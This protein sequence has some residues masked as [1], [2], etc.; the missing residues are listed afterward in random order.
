M[1]RE[2]TLDVAIVG[3]GFAGLYMLYKAREQGMNAKVFER[4]DGVGG[5]WYWNRYPGARC[6]VESF[7]YSYSF[8]PELD[9]EWNW[10]ERYPTQPE[11]LAYLNHVADRFDLRD[12]I[13]LETE[14]VSAHYD[15]SST[16]WNLT[17]ARGHEFTTKFFVMASGNLSTAQIPSFPGLNDFTG[18]TYHTGNWPE[19]DVDF[20]GKSVA[21]IGTGSSGIQVIPEIAQQAEHVTVLQRTPSFS[22]P[23]RNTPLT[24]GEI[25]E[26]KKNYAS[27]RLT[28]RNSA[29]GAPYPPSTDSAFDVSDE[30]RTARFEQYW[31]MGGAR[32]M[33]AFADLMT[34]QKA[35]DTVAEFVR[36]KISE[37]VADKDRA[38]ILTPEGFALGSKRVCVDTNYYETFNRDN[39]DI[40][41]VSASPIERITADGI[42]TARAR[43]EVDAIVFATGYDAM[44]GALLAVDIRGKGG[45]SL[46]DQW[47]GG[48]KTYLGV[49]VSGFPN[50]FIVTGPQSPSVLGN[51]VVS[52]EQHVEFIAD[53]I[54]FMDDKGYITSQPEFDA[55]EEWVR[56]V[57]EVG[58]TTL[59][60]T[61][62]SWYVGANIPGK[63][64]VFMPYIGGVG[65]FRAMCDEIAAEGYRGFSFS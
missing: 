60:S 48:P 30:E 43:V 59:F 45:T 47:S 4:G 14:I 17:S 38:K 52:I 31:S 22:M 1:N 29:A 9:Q 56:H 25:S 13:C 37:S 53:H 26:V 61:G 20:R 46:R 41:D 27:L 23:A 42:A 15:D 34:S 8:S 7:Y 65:N 39:V 51:V 44:T 64:R 57:A 36:S 55:Q 10:T 16:L 21:I 62:A 28:S 2:Q 11:I 40:I 54:K 58:E 50:M 12:D 18:E 3:A 19:N 33:N 6:D 24:D 49:A 63:P 35:N 32:I 5:T